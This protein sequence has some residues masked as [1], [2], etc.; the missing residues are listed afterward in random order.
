[1]FSQTVNE[2]PETTSNGLGLETNLGVSIIVCCH[3]SSELLPATLRHLKAQVAAG[4]PWEVVLVDNASTDS[5]ANL[6]RDIW[7]DSPPSAPL[8]IVHESRLGL[9][10]ARQRGIAEA[11]YEFL[12]FI[13]D[14]NWV[15]PDWVRNVW[16]VMRDHPEVGACGGLSKPEF[17]GPPPPWFAEYSHLYA[18]MPESQQTGNV[19]H[20]RLLWGAGLT[21]RRSALARLSEFDFESV[22]VG[23]TGKQLSSGEDTELCLALR[24]AG[25]SLWLEPR[26]HFNHYLPS[27]RLDW[28][29]LRRL[30]FGSAFAT[31]AHDALYFVGKPPRRGLLRVARTLRELWIWQVFSALGAMLMRPLSLLSCSVSPKD[32]DPKVIQIEFQKGRFMG[33]IAAFPW[34]GRRRRTL[35]RS[36][37]RALRIAEPI[38]EGSS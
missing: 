26:L 34:Y 8:K 17:G 35:R 4:V 1:M 37:A 31:P 27:K 16:D 9:A 11:T 7:E 3:N 20:S 5:T 38:I 36:C 14:D 15:D 6:A 24:M 32:G 25:W 22:L 12:C 10:F 13:D 21:L 30:A 29:Y 18:V 23:R 28:N 19:P 2:P 33:L